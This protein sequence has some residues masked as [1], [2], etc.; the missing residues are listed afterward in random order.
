MPLGTAC[1]SWYAMTK[2]LTMAVI[3]TLT[4]SEAMMLIVEFDGER[5]QALIH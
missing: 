5:E 3:I 4:Q 2:F 1:Q